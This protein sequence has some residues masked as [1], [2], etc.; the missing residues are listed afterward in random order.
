MKKIEIRDKN[1]KEFDVTQR[2][3]LAALKVGEET[4]YPISRKFIRTCTRHGDTRAR[5]DFLTDDSIH[6]MTAEQ[7]DVGNEREMLA[8]LVEK[9]V[10]KVRENGIGERLYSRGK[11]YNLESL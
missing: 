1:A 7:L 4:P 8:L 5:I 11:N 2:W 3:Y 10:L 9:E 6:A